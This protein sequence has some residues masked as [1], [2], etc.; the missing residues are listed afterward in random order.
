MSNT[1]TTAQPIELAVAKPQRPG[2]YRRA[3]V[4]C[5]ASAVVIVALL[6]TGF[7]NADQALVTDFT[8][9]ALTPHAAEP[10]GTDWMGRSLL[11]RTVTGL[12]LSIL[13][14]LFAATVS[15][16]IALILGTLAALGPKWVDNLVSWLINLMLGLP[17]MLL[18][19]LI[20]VA[21]GRGFWGV[22]IGVAVTHWPSLARVIRSGPTPGKWTW[23]WCLCCKVKCS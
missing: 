18:L 11:A 13:I 21:I 15:A 7:A 12:A 23:G 19:I 5:I 14:G 20:S 3:V 16:I 2:P 22:A 17:H 4:T 9:K 1:T 8:N 6:I 10:F